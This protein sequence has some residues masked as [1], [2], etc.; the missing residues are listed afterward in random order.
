MIGVVLAGGSGTRLRPLTESTNKHLLD[1][2][3][4]PMLSYGLEAVAA[5]GISEA[6]VVTGAEHQGSFR[7]ILA[8]AGR[9]GLDRIG[10]AAQSG[11]RGIADA[12]RC[13]R[14]HAEGRELLVLLGDN[15]FG[16]SLAGMVEA[17]RSGADPALIALAEHEDLSSCGVARLDG[18]RVV[19][20]VEKPSAGGAPPPT[21]WAVPGVYLY[22]EGAFEEIEALRPSARG[23]LEIT[24]LNNRYA[25]RGELGHVR[26]AGWWAD[27]GTPGGLRRAA[28]LVRAHGVNGSGP[29]AC[30]ATP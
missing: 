7:P 15:L 29:R 27:A 19:E 30:G 11:P 24:D 21:G 1:V 18:E 17:F 4:R 10:L 8:D 20:I 6:V 5:A 16:A 28:D 22:S 9:Y 23:E 12:L 26:L 13:A 3:G 2:A 14:A 25:A